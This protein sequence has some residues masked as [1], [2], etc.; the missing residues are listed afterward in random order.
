[1]VAL[2]AF[3]MELLERGQLACHPPCQSEPSPTA[4][5]GGRHPWRPGSHSSGGGRIAPSTQTKPK[6]GATNHIEIKPNHHTSTRQGIT[7]VSPRDSPHVFVELC[8]CAAGAS[9]YEMWECPWSWRAPRRALRDPERAQPP[10]RGCPVCASVAAARA[11][12]RVPVLVT[13]RSS[14]GCSI[15]I[16]IPPGD[17]GQHRHCQAPAWLHFGTRRGASAQSTRCHHPAN[18]A[19]WSISTPFSLQTWRSRVFTASRPQKQ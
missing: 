16:L 3:L 6:V 14:E 4:E 10:F 5:R 2:V 15:S 13:P 1:M 18:G 12:A 9:P 7:A 19:N 8:K 17:V 11:R